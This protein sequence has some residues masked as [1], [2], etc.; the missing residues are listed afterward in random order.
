MEQQN[1]DPAAE[2]RIRTCSR[3]GQ[4]F[5]TGGL[6]CG[7]CRAR[8]GNRGRLNPKLSFRDKQVIW[9]ACHAMSN[10]VIAFELHLTEGTVKEY[11][12]RIFR[13]TGAVNRVDLV[14]FAIREGIF[15]PFEPSAKECAS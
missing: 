11:F 6:I 15:D 1:Q 3:C 4:E 9:L 13:K 2:P 10:K 12:G 14:V 5:S 8:A 7:D